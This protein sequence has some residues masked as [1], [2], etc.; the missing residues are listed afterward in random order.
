MAAAGTDDT[1]AVLK[2]MRE[3]PVNDMMT[4][5]GKIRQDGRVMRD[6]YLFEAKKPSESKSDWDLLKRTATVPANDAAAP[7]A[8]SPCPLV[9]R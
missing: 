3:I 5:N 4:K 7:L 1:D 8:D 6:M 2:K 9:G